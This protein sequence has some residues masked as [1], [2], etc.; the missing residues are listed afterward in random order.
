MIVTNTAEK[1]KGMEAEEEVR[2]GAT[3]V[4]LKAAVKTKTNLKKVSTCLGWTGGR[5]SWSRAGLYWHAPA[6]VVRGRDFIYVRNGGS[7]NL[8]TQET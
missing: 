7:S 8:V 6:G 5:D 1:E 2:T 3:K 4:T